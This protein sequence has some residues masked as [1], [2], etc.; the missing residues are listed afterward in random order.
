[1]D[2]K[3]LKTLKELAESQGKDL[4]DL[5][6][7]LECPVCLTNDGWGIPGI[8]RCV[9]CDTVMIT[10]KF[11]EPPDILRGSNV[12]IVPYLKPHYEGGE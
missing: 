11:H 7:D 2:I 8:T 3:L 12:V 10:R 4:S 1:M 6:V 5:C 9:W